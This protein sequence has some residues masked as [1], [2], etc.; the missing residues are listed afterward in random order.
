MRNLRGYL[1]ASPTFVYVP[2]VAMPSEGRPLEA[3]EAA[4][5]RENFDRV[6]EGEK[7]LAVSQM[8]VL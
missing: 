7:A 6:A 3:S 2:A 1:W 5:E 4:A 8:P